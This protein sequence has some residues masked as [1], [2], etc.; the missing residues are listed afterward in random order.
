MLTDILSQD[1]LG[2]YAYQVAKAEPT[3]QELRNRFVR[4]F[5]AYVIQLTK[6]TGIFPETLLTQ[7]I[8]EN[9]D[10][11]G[12]IFQGEV[13]I[14]A[15]NIFGIKATP[16]WTG[17]TITLPTP[18]D[19]DSF[20]KFRVYPTYQDSMKDYINFLKVNPTYKKHGVFSATNYTTQLERIAAA[21]YAENPNY[22]T[23]LKSVSA[24]VHNV[25]KEFKTAPT[26]NDTL[27]KILVGFA[28]VTGLIILTEDHE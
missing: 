4:N 14:K 1:E 16:N 18:G 12:V 25:L 19:K 17:Q 2:L 9:A 13:A 22:F 28:I 15:K 20:S 23:M 3:N 21:G 27:K 6:G 7:A 26:K 10:R 8:I 24:K 5:G 11:N